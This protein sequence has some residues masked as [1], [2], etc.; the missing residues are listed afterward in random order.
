[1]DILDQVTKIV[2]EVETREG[3]TETDLVVM[4]AAIIE[5]LG[6]Q[7]NQCVVTQQWKQSYDC[8]VRIF[9]LVGDILAEAA[10]K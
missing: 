8:L 3:K 4:R 10:S 7:Y 9:Q 5:A 1:M 2:N 6:K